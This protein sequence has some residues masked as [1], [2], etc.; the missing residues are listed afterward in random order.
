M[1]LGEQQR[2]KFKEDGS[3]EEKKDLLLDDVSQEGSGRWLRK[4]QNRQRR[5]TGRCDPLQQHGG[6]MR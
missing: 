6:R 2:L 1:M 4:R 3:T 5:R